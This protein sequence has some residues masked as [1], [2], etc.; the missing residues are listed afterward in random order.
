MENPGSAAEEFHKQEYQAL[1]AECL[2]RV[3]TMDLILYIG[4]L[5]SA[6]AASWLLS[7]G[8]HPPAFWCAPFAIAIM[9]AI[10]YIQQ[11]MMLSKLGDYLWKIESLFADPQ[12]AGWQHAG[13]PTHEKIWWLRPIN[14]ALASYWFVFILVTFMFS[15][16][17]IGIDLPDS[18][19]N[20]VQLPNT[21]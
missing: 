17:H 7:S 11:I 2:M 21:R 14:L 20:F 3:R 6:V 4:M 10:L 1:R 18:I 15:A 8:N 9:A 12:L 16:E 5:S 19:R 13:A